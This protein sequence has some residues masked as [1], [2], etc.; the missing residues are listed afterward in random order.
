MNTPKPIPP[1][2]T[3]ARYKG[4]PNRPPCRCTPCTRAA[5]RDDA[6]RTIDRLAGRPRRVPSAPV[7]DHIHKLHAADINDTQ[8]ARAAGL[9]QTAVGKVMNHP[10]V[11]RNTAEKILA[12]PLTHKPPIGYV[13]ATGAV[14]RVRAL[15]V[16]CHSPVAMAHTLGVSPDYFGDLARGMFARVLA[17]FDQRLRDL[18][19]Q[20]AGSRGKSTRSGNYAARHG[21][22]G[23]LAWDDIDDPKALPDTSEGVVLNLQQAGAERLAE[24]RLLGSAGV[25]PEQIAQRLGVTVD[26][27]RHRMRTHL[28]HLYLE[29]TA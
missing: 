11:A 16:Q 15:Y 17:D 5:S 21:W 6:K 12:V 9:H 25:Q 13:P 19:A 2:G 14:R 29:L 24:M 26:Y 4:N 22:H 27:V 28:P 7:R 18:Y 20:L 3:S 8:I 1:H 10:T 23:P